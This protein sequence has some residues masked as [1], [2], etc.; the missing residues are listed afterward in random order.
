MKMQSIIKPLCYVAFSICLFVGLSSFNGQKEALPGNPDPAQ[1][2]WFDLDGNIGPYK[3]FM[4][5]NY[6]AKG[7]EK[8]GY[9]YY[10]DRPNT[11]FSLVMIRHES[12]LAGSKKIVYEYT[13]K[14]EHTGTF[15]GYFS[16]RG[17]NFSGTFTNVRTG[18]KFN[19]EL[20]EAY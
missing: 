12:A 2:L 19:F 6:D 11:K 13:P 20:M 18:K 15:N 16:T 14:G 7:G 17:I 8:C 4:H 5:I 9:Y 10:K 3:V 1:E